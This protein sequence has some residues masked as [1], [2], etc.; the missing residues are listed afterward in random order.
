MKIKDGRYKRERSTEKYN[1]KAYY[2]ISKDVDETEA[3]IERSSKSRMIRSNKKTA[4]TLYKSSHNDEC[5]CCIIQ[6]EGKDIK[7]KCKC[8]KYFHRMCLSR[9]DGV[10]PSRCFCGKSI[11]SLKEEH[12]IYLDFGS[13]YLC[14]QCK[15]PNVN[16]QLLNCLHGLCYLCFDNY[17]NHKGSLSPNDNEFYCRNCEVNKTIS[18]ILLI[19]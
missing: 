14:C 16:Y 17:M 7:V 3:H 9:C 13:K 1:Y 11:N 5:P 10:K 12:N 19:L 8:G 15:E 2:S 6:I 4:E 18:N